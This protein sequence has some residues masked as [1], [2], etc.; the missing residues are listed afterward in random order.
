VVREAL[1]EE[2]LAMLPPAEA[3]A[4]FIA[5]RSEGLT[6]S[7][8]QLLEQWL[9][10]DEGHRKCFEAAD[11]GWQAFGDSSGDEILSA[12]RT[13]A[14]APRARS[15]IAGWP[16][17]AAA[18]V[19]IVAVGSAWFLMRSGTTF[20]HLTARGEVKEFRLTDGSVITL[21]GDSR[22][23]GDFGDDVRTIQLHQGRVMF[24]VASDPARPFA[25]TA[26][27]RRIV[28]VGTRFD[29]NILADGLSVSLFEGRV[30]VESLDSSTTPI[31]LEPG[32][33]F[34]ERNGIL[35]IRGLNAAGE[36]MEDSKQELIRFE[37]QPLAEAV[38][39]MNRYSTEQIVIGDPA[40]GSLRVSGQFRAGDSKRFAET[41]AEVH[42]LKVVNRNHRI[43]LVRD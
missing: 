39:V 25:V 13:H 3:A 34:V 30:N 33:Q 38:A 2:R 32:Q 41:L 11:R 31:A 10:K 6:T 42:G 43:E 16:I 36:G 28:A 22:V 4:V 35:D 15:R 24:A 27:S 8:Q 5:R 21:S 40:I 23:T 17:A 37:D 12:M 29:V 26:A 7:E 9:A 14:L 20:E 1:T 18:A 19:L